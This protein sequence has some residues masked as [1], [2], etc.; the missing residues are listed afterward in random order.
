MP[1][2]VV[3]AVGAVIAPRARVATAARVVVAPQAKVAKVAT[4]EREVMAHRAEARVA[5]G[6]K[7]PPAMGVVE[8][9]DQED[10]DERR[11]T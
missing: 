3:T 9:M 11:K 5:K 1:A 6:A 7:G 8:V 4:V 10:N 2:E